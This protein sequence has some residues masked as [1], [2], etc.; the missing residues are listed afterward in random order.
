MRYL[1]PY[2]LFESFSDEVRD[3][4]K[5]IFAELEDNGLTVLVDASP[6]HSGFITICLDNGFTSDNLFTLDSEIIES[7]LRLIDYLRMNKLYLNELTIMYPSYWILP[8]SDI[9]EEG[10]FIKGELG[11]KTDSDSKIRQIKIKY[12]KF[13]IVFG[14]G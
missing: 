12:S 10:I 13:D 3:D 2:Q 14:E 9:T 4:I 5:D 8:A 7:I 1:K 11:L 6:Y